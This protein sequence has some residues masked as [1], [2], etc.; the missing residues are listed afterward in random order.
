[1]QGLNEKDLA[2]DS[3]TELFQR[4]DEFSSFPGYHSSPYAALKN[5]NVTN[6]RK[7]SCL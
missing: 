5:A 3:I 7:K 1:M 6:E 2:Y 4:C